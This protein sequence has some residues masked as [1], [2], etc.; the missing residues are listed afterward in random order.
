MCVCK[1]ASMCDDCM[2]AFVC[3][4]WCG[5]TF[6]SVCV[7]DD[8]ARVCDHREC[9]GVRGCACVRVCDE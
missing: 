7:L 4:C 2:S 3:M 6:H 1:Q 8:F 9:G 5:C